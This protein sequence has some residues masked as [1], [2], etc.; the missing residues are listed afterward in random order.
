MPIGRLDIFQNVS[1]QFR[2]G[3]DI[4]HSNNLPSCSQ[5]KKPLDRFFWSWDFGRRLRLQDG[6]QTLPAVS[7]SL[8]SRLTVV[9]LSGGNRLR[10]GIHVVTTPTVMRENLTTPPVRAF[11]LKWAQNREKWFLCDL[12]VTSEDGPTKAEKKPIFEENSL[13]KALLWA[14]LSKN[15]RLPVGRKVLLNAILP[16]PTN[17]PV[18]SPAQLNPGLLWT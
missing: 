4:A 18:P 15:Q 7:V 3:P 6:E 8:R 5:A 12:F 13:W 10:H 14:I 17:S 9:R 1:V 2:I 11:G 16:T